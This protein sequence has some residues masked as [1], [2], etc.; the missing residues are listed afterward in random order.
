[1]AMTTLSN[2]NYGAPALGKSTGL[3]RGFSTPQ[4]A[5]VERPMQFQNI[6]FFAS[7]NLLKPKANTIQPFGQLQPL[8]QTEISNPYSEQEGLKNLN[9]GISL[10]K[11]YEMKGFLT[12]NERNPAIIQNVLSG[13]SYTADMLN[14][15]RRNQNQLAALPK[16]GQALSEP[17]VPG[18]NLSGQYSGESPEVIERN[19]RNRLQNIEEELK[20]YQS[21]SSPDFKTL[22]EE[23]I[24]SKAKERF[25]KEW[26]NKTWKDFYKAPD[27]AAVERTR[28]QAIKDF[29]E[30]KG[31]KAR[32]GFS[33]PEYALSAAQEGA[34]SLFSR[35]VGD[36]ENKYAYEL[37]KL[38][39]AKQYF[40]SEEGKKRI[41]TNKKF[42][43][44]Y[45]KDTPGFQSLNLSEDILRS[46]QAGGTT[47][48]EKDYYKKLGAL[49]PYQKTYFDELVKNSKDN[50]G[51]I[52]RNAE[53]KARDKV[54]QDFN[55]SIGANDLYIPY[56]YSEPF[57]QA[58]VQY[59]KGTKDPL[60]SF[61]NFNDN[62]YRNW[63]L[64]QNA[65]GAALG[66]VKAYDGYT[67]QELQNFIP[68]FNQLPKITY[69]F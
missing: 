40:D 34:A 66:G 5:K 45:G 33:S 19:L 46:R 22:S 54:M 24:A 60:G 50:K 4:Q 12:S 41:D 26:G 35:S 27:L 65:K 57:I 48:Y 64:T 39:A 3:G 56:D 8:G 53:N 62:D 25:N 37:R 67:R 31:S 42:L 13:K 44:F 21:V 43:E 32:I 38:N 28:Q 55:K 10:A 36:A 30:G 23:E 1:M 2:L 18:K 61:K 69:R 58:K 51:S 6:D 16:A 11:E 63:V 59:F 52:D 20:L 49:S 15:Y 17:Y 7:Q 68:K 47:P 14:E 29:N 9:T